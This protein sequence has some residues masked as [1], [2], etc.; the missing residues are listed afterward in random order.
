MTAMGNKFKETKS[1]M[2]SDRC[3]S[4]DTFQKEIARGNPLTTAFVVLVPYG[5]PDIFPP[6]PIYLSI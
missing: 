6:G 1:S 3:H 4:R 2:E 5:G